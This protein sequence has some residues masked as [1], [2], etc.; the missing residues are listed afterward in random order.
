MKY[1]FS[2][3]EHIFLNLAISVFVTLLSILQIAV[4]EQD[5]SASKISCHRD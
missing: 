1:L 3:K 5:E 4:E 2:K